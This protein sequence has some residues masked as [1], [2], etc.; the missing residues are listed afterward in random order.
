MN[1]L[2]K[3][4]FKKNNFSNYNYNFIKS[5][6]GTDLTKLV[7]LRPISIKEPWAA[8]ITKWNGR[9]FMWRDFKKKGK[10]HFNF[11]KKENREEKFKRGTSIQKNVRLSE[12][13]SRIVD[14][15]RVDSHA[16]LLSEL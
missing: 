14:F 2:N 11:L 13:W 16:N 9:K 8:I 15:G 3:Y 7:K 12:F 1:F 4:M 10:S 6:D 5:S